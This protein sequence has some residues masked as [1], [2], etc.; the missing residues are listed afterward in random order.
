M[1]SLD[2][3]Y[4]FSNHWPEGFICFAFFTALFFRCLWADDITPHPPPSLSLPECVFAGIIECVSC[5]CL[6]RPGWAELFCLSIL[7]A[8]G[9]GGLS[10]D[11]YMHVYDTYKLFCHVIRSTD[12]LRRTHLC[13]LCTLTQVA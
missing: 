4:H 12:L 3:P 13:P 10:L 2:R 11:D 8:Y 5:R 6:Y 7:N 1:P 9:L